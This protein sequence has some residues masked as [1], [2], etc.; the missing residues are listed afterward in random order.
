MDRQQ[1]HRDGRAGKGLGRHDGD[2]GTGV[3]IDAAAAL[4]RDR[5]ADDVDDAEHAPALA[6]DFLHRRQ[7]VE[8]LARLADR[9]IE[10]VALDDRVAV[11]EFGGRLGMRRQP[12]QLLDQMRADRAGDIGRAAAE[13]LD[14]A[15]V[16]KLVCGELDAA[17]M[18][19]LKARFEPAAQ[20]ACDYLGLLGDLLPHEMGVFALVEGLVRPGDRRWGLGGRTAVEGR[21]LEPVGAHQRD[22]AVIEVDDAAGMPHQGRCVGGDEHLALTDPQHDGAAVARGDDRLGP[23]RVEHGEPVGAGDQPQRRAHRRVERTLRHRRDQM[24]QHLAV[25]LGA[26]NNTGALKPRPQCRGILDDAVMDDRDA[27]RRHR[28]AGGRC[29]RSARHASP[30]AYGRCRMSP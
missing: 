19:R 4:A 3:Q 8:G 11:A 13:D 12:R 15:D 17:Q 16:E 20:G 25:G 23:S 27:V 2:L 22:F 5:A 6:L 29:G 24:R 26:E 7:G 30:S 10:R 28:N 18:R 21:G 9:D 1:R 14:A